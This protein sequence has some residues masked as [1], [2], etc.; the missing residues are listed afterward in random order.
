VWKEVRNMLRKKKGQSTLEYI[1]LFA[2]VVAAVIAFA[3]VNLRGGVQRV[4]Q[5][6]GAKITD[7]ADRFRDGVN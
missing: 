4:Q 5:E 3:Y 6:A 7:A 1:V 2:A